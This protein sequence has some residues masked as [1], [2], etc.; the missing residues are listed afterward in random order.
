MLCT[1]VNT[2]EISPPK[3]IVQLVPSIGEKPAAFFVP[4][5]SYSPLPTF[6]SE[7]I[8]SIKSAKLLKDES[9]LAISTV[10]LWLKTSFLLACPTVVPLSFIIIPKPV[11]PYLILLTISLKKVASF[12]P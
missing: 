4:L 8:F 7:I 6:F 2:S 5:Y 3:T 11:L 9:F 1:S 10:L 12:A